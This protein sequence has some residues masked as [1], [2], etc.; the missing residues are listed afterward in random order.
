MESR[1]CSNFFEQTKGNGSSAISLSLNIVD[2]DIFSEAD[3]SAHESIVPVPPARPPPRRGR[4]IRPCA[5]TKGEKNSSLLARAARGCVLCVSRRIEF[6]RRDHRGQSSLQD[7][8]VSGREKLARSRI[9]YCILAEYPQKRTRT[10]HK[11]ETT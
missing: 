3:E 2:R 10:L 6:S 9:S 11:G 7:D 1:F 8:P 4:R 5:V